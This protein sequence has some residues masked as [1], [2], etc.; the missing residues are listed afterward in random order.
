MDHQQ[1]MIQFIFIDQSLYKSDQI[2]WNL[3]S[4]LFKT[5]LTNIR[6]IISV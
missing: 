5:P 1:T 3:N 6:Y 4:I 2:K